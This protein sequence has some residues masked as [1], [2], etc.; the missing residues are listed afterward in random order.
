M[1]ER[2]HQIYILGSSFCLDSENELKCGQ[3]GNRASSWK[4]N[5]DLV[6]CFMVGKREEGINHGEIH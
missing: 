3:N 1:K 6:S 4:I 2:D 5:V